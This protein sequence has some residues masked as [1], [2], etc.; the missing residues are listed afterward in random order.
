MLNPQGREKGDVKE[1]IDKA[2]AL[3]CVEHPSYVSDSEQTIINFMQ[4]LQIW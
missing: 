4:S 2:S 3:L 1:I